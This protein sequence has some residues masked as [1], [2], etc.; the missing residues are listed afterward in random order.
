[1]KF[2]GYITNVV[3]TKND[4]KKYG[5]LEAVAEGIAT[6]AKNRMIKS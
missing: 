5:F 4:E 2:Q 1:M 3:V 6:I